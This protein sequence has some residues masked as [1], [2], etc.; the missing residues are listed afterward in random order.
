MIQEVKYNGC[1]AS[2]SDYE[3]PD[4]HMAIALNL[5]PEDGAL[6][7]VLPPKVVMQLGQG[8]RVA[9]IHKTADFKNNRYCTAEFCY[10][11]M[12]KTARLKPT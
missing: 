6:K 9:F 2:P 5:V 1:T 4:G 8:R 7:P 12:Y 11:F 10:F 3:S